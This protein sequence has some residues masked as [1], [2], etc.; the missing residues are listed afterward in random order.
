VGR[1]L[2]RV[3]FA[4]AVDADY[5]RSQALGRVSQSTVL[6]D[7]PLT[8]FSLF[9][10]PSCRLLRQSAHF[11]FQPPPVGESEKELTA[12]GQRANGNCLDCRA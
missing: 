6:P 10:R 3:P 2:P 5:S 9:S 8:D 11:T 7:D 4:P 1:D 12:D